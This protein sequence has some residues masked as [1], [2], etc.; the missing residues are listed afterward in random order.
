M[1]GIFIL[2][3]PNKVFEISLKFKINMECLVDLSTYL[4]KTLL[5]RLMF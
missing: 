4:Q 5:K 2:L 1:A 3:S